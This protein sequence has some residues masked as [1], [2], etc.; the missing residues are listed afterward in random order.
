M[1]LEESNTGI[2]ETPTQA[3][4]MES[5]GE[6]T[7]SQ[8]AVR[9]KAGETAEKAREAGAE[10]VHQAAG[11]GA[12]FLDEQR[13]HVAEVMHHC[14]DAFR[15]AADDLRQKHDPNLA[16]CAQA[17]ADRLDKGSN[18]MRNRQFQGIREDVENFARRQPQL[19]Y[20][21]LLVAGLVLSRFLKASSQT[22]SDSESPWTRREPEGAWSRP[23]AESPTIQRVP[24]DIPAI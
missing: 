1:K 3:S 18:Y 19:F 13:T 10:A 2:H 6:Q 9:Q 15:T 4:P 21:G 5:R 24:A 7:S 20:G 12:A 8:E 14:S 17:L 11:Q 23:E 22:P 16:S